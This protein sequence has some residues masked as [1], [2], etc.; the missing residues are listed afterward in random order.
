MKFTA[1]QQI[2]HELLLRS[3]IENDLG[4]FYG[5]TGLVLFFVHYF[6]QTNNPVFEDTANELV[7]ELMEEIYQELPIGFASGLS[8]IGWGL[9]YLIQNGLYKGDSLEI[10][11]EIDNKIMEKDLRRMNDYTLDSGLEGL[12]HYILAHLKGVMTKHAKLPFDEIY[13]NDL[14]QT[15]LNISW[16]SKFSKDFKILSENYL[17]FYET[18]TELNYS[19]K[20]SSFI[21]DMKIDIKN[22]HSLPLG[23]RKGLSGYMLKTIMNYEGSLYY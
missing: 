15:V 22:L 1:E 18:R 21:E 11:E 9:E 23:L 6:E 19:L 7:E 10:C 3:S 4:L 8:G 20:L 16:K 5:K 14:Y 12:L 13:L 17:H 2:I